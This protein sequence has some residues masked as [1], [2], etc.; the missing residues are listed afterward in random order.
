MANEAV[1]I[2]GLPKFI[3]E[4]K[5]META[6]PAEVDKIN[7][8]TAN[9]VAKDAQ[10]RAPRRTGRLRS[11]IHVTGGKQVIVSTTVPYATFVHFGS[12]H[13][14]Q[15]VPFLTDA[16]DAHAKTIVP[17]YENR[18]ETLAERVF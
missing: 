5:I 7:L 8:E 2:E 16:L 18:I 3:T 17:V 4:C 13:N 14:P 6:L 15:P 11:S 12:I 9:A 10:R 1:R